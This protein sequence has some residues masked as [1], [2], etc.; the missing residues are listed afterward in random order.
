MLDTATCERTGKKF[1]IGD[2]FF[3]AD[4]RTGEWSFVGR[5]ASDGQYEYNITISEL[6]ASAESLSNTMAHLNETPWFKPQKFFDFFT[7]FRENYKASS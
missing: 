4:K 7:R 2:G 1:L 6:M 5:N 3:V